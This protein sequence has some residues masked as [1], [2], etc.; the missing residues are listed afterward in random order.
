MRKGPPKFLDTAICFYSFTVYVELGLLIFSSLSMSVKILS[1]FFVLF[2]Q[3]PLIW[4]LL[5]KIYG[6]V[7]KVSALGKKAESGNLWFLGHKLQEIYETFDFLEKF[8]KTI[9]GL[10]SFW[11]RLWGARIGKNVNWT[12]GSKIV[13][14]PHIHVGDRT[15]IG[16]MSYLSAHAIKKKDGRYTLFVKD[17]EIKEDVVIAYLV[18]VAPGVTIAPKAFIDS[19]A[20][21]YPNTPIEEGQKYE[22]F[23][24][25]LNDRFNFLFKR[26]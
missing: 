21:I 24:E 12:S 17:V 10:Y 7:P 6:P 19:G 13:D 8:L 9:P 1:V 2:L 18:T 16:N 22:R 5:H 26:D 3:A 23:E 11:L 4:R 20:V 25:L 15:L 14:R